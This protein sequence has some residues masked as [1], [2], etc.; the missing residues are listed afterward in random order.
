MLAL[1]TSGTFEPKLLLSIFALHFS[2]RMASKV[3]SIMRNNIWMYD[4]FLGAAERVVCARSGMQAYIKIE[5]FHFLSPWLLM[6]A[7]FR[8]RFKVLVS[9][10]KSLHSLGVGY[11]KTAFC[12]IFPLL[13]C[14]LLR[15]CFYPSHQQ[16]GFG[17]RAFLAVALQLWNALEKVA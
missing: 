7:I 9:T 4:S 11:L 10:Y 2:A 3:I 12:V 8:A 15:R 14:I 5:L 1:Y 6:P 16:K 17:R 13:R